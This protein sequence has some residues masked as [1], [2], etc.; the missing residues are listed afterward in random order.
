MIKGEGSVIITIGANNGIGSCISEALLRKGY[1]VA[2]LDIEGDSYQHE[3][4]STSR[5]SYSSHVMADPSKVGQQL[6]EK[7]LTVKP[8]VTPDL[9]T[10]VCLFL[11][12]RFSTAIGRFMAKMTENERTKQ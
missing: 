1:S 9:Q 12:R 3:I 11:C 8:I 4:V 10:R 7:T 5:Y 6:A 2:G